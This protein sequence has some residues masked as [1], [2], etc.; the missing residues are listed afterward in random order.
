VLF[1]VLLIEQVLGLRQ[2][3]AISIGVF[4]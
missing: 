4:S 1:A 2:F 3:G